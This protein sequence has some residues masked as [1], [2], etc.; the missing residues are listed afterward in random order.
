MA[1]GDWKMLARVLALAAVAVAFW[2][3]AKYDY[4]QPN[5]LPTGAPPASFSAERA[6]A[7]LGRVL[8]P[9]K[10]HPV[11]SDENAAV[12]ARIQ[13]EFAALGV[14]SST[15]TAFACN[16]WRGF[17]AIPCATVTDILAD[18]V[19]GE[20]K[21]IVLLAHYDSVPAGP[22]ASDD[23]SGVATVLETARALRSRAGKSRHPVL[24]VITD[25]EEAGL[26]G[27]QAFLQNPALKARVGVVVNVEARG[28]RGRSVLFQTSPGDGNLIDLYARSVPYFATSSLYAEIYRLLPNDTDLTLFIRQGFPAFNFAFA[29]NVADYHTPLDRRD[30]LSKRTLQQQGDNML[31]VAAKLQRT[32]YADLAGRNA[33]YLDIFGAVLPRFPTSWA[34]PLAVV[35]LLIMIA[36]AFRTEGITRRDWMLAI[37]LPPALLIVCGLVG[38]LLHTL[39]ET[40]SGQPDPSYAYPIAL[41]EGLAF[42]MVASVLFV[43]R[44]TSAHAATMSIWL[45]FAILSVATAAFV[46][47]LSPYFLFPALLASLAGLVLIAAPHAMRGTWGDAVF[48]PA[49]IAALAIWLGLVVAGEGLMGLKLHPLFTVPAG[50]AAMTLLPYLDAQHIRRGVWLALI[51][52]S[53]AG[54]LIATVIA[55]L[56]PA[57]SRTQAQRLSIRYVEDPSSGKSSW[58]LDAGAPLP[59]PLRAAAAFARDPVQL[60]PKPFPTNYVAP[61]GGLRYP[62]PRADVV[63]DAIVDGTRRLTIHL[64]GSPQTMTLGIVIP[65]SARLHSIDI[66]G[67]HLEVPKDSDTDTL[68]A[69]ASRD[70]AGET[71]GLEFASRSQISIVIAEQHYDLPPFAA[72]LVAARPPNAVP[73]Q[74][75]DYTLLTNTLI[76]KAH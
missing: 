39:A 38:F 57:Y 72:K 52:A 32:N 49:E 7:T 20:G 46:P 11:S 48:G 42:G 75:G 44:M 43:A 22:G 63:S 12:R 67:Q 36:A 65:K 66:H 68:L 17:A 74:T 30:N 2:A 56:Q 61:A 18:V 69:C 28:T 3:M 35:C 34:L 19:P 23:E 8:G 40:I 4:K 51:G 1:T 26:L 60:L 27:A 41:R 45:W 64:Q 5:V 21:A 33:V 15:Y 50:F 73:S 31:G 24:A 55:G 54:A 14:K 70:C 9:E 13:Q 62:P 37:V 6:Y 10:P 76:V 29:D 53:G 58:A 59:A 71:V 47:G 25:G 16:T